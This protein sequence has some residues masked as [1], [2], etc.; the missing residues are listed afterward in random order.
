MWSRARGRLGVVIVVEPKTG[1]IL[2]MAV[3]PS[4]PIQ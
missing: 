4:L 3:R 2:A 1:A